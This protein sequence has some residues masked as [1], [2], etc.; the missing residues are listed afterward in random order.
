MCEH[1]EVNVLIETYTERT[2]QNMATNMWKDGG[3]RQSQS[4][5]FQCENTALLNAVLHFF[6][7]PR[8]ILQKNKFHQVNV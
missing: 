1:A 4:P 7:S 8:L 6:F 3:E 2:L 5:R